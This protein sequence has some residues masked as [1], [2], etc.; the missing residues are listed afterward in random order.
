MGDSFLA[1]RTALLRQMEALDSMELGSL[2]AEFRSSPSGAQT[3]PYFE[4]RVWIDGANLSQRVSKGD[5]P[6]LQAA[7]DNRASLPSALSTHAHLLLTPASILNP[8]G[9]IRRDAL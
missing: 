5:A 6:A 2:K 3:G 4:H 9:T 8:E 7:I 1:K